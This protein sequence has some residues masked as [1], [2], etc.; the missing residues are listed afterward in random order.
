MSRSYAS[1]PPWHLHGGSWIDLLYW[2]GEIADRIVQDMFVR[3]CEVFTEA[4]LLIFAEMNLE[5]VSA[6]HLSLSVK[7][8]RLVVRICRARLIVTRRHE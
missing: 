4:N 8:R 5:S 6:W 3:V 1:S 7:S 2:T